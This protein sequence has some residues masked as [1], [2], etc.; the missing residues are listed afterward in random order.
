MKF[1]GLK[2]SGS[3]AIAIAWTLLILLLCSIPQR[4]LP[5]APDW[6]G[7]DKI[8]HFTL[9][10]I[11]AQLWLR[12]AAKGDNPLVL[13]PAHRW[14]LWLAGVGYGAFTELYQALISWAFAAGRSADVADMLADALGFT[15]SLLLKGRWR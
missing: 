9:F 5:D 10:A 2:F 7:L 3:R 8:V 12:A 11:L 6:L 4:A 15:V 1:S 14:R 13:N